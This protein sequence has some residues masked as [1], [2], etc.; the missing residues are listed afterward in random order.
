MLSTPRYRPVVLLSFLVISILLHAA[1]IVAL[2]DLTRLFN[3]HIN[4]LGLLEETE[5]EVSLVDP[6]ATYSSDFVNFVDYGYHARYIFIANI[7]L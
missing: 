1:L 6:E 4:R 5:I 7:I 2:P 3:I